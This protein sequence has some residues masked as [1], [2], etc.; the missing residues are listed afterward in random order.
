VLSPQIEVA[1]ILQAWAEKEP[2][3][4]SEAVNAWD[5]LWARLK[6]LPRE[7]FKTEYYTVVYNQCNCR[8]IQ[9]EKEKKPSIAAD[10]EKL[11]NFCFLEAPQLDGDPQTVANFKL[12]KNRAIKLQGR[13]LDSDK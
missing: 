3:H 11:L 10:A 6:D 7:Q 1:E 4:F 5:G 8:L 2:N 13:K 12:L 9:A